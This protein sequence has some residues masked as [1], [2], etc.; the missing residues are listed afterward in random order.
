V[1]LDPKFALAYNNRGAAYY[2]LG[3]ADRALAN[4]DKAVEVDPGCADAYENRAQVWSDRGD[5]GRAAADLAKAKELR[6]KKAGS[7]P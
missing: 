3:D 2:R 5:T 4:Y 1:E 7:S 6:A